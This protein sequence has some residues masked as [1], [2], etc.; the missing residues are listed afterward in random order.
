MELAVFLLFAFLAVASA[1]V[2]VTHRNPVHSTMS[3]VVTFFS[4]AV[5]YVLLGSP[6]LAALQLLLY[7]GAILV[8][9][10][11]VLML[12]NIQRESSGQIQAGLGQLVVAIGASLVFTSLVAYLSWQAYQSI[13]L[14]PLR[15]EDVS[16]HRIARELFTTYLLPFEIIGLLLLVAVVAA[17]V[18]AR[19]PSEPVTPEAPRS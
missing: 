16:L 13:P 1:L 6:F 5:L 2:V 15:P 4:T 14:A 8:L 9:F 17:T 19:R 11:F 12:L 18:L 10:L 3:L 7:T